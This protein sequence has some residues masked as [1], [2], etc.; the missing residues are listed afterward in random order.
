MEKKVPKSKWWVRFNST[1]LSFISKQ[2]GT[3]SSIKKARK[4]YTEKEAIETVLPSDLIDLFPVVTYKEASKYISLKDNLLTPFRVD[5]NKVRVG[6]RRTIFGQW[7]ARIR[8]N[9]S[10][11]TFTGSSYLS[12]IDAIDMALDWANIGEGATLQPHPWKRSD[13][14]HIKAEW[15]ED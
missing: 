6:V 14:S 9:T 7:I 1:H 2:G 15:E 11:L 5:L 12:P 13:G 8:L 4:W 3:T 10:T